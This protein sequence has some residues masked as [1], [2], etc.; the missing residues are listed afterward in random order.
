MFLKMRAKNKM[1]LI[2]FAMLCFFSTFCM[3]EVPTEGYSNEEAQRLFSNAPDENTLST[4]T[5]SN[6][7]VL[8]RPYR[9]EPNKPYVLVVMLP[10]TGGNA[11]QLYN[12]AF[13]FSFHAQKTQFVLALQ[14][15]TASAADYNTGAAWADTIARYEVSVKTT[16][17]A[18]ANEAQLKPLQ[19]ILA[20]YSV[21]G[22]LSW[23]LLQRKTDWFDGAIVMGS[24]ST[25]RGGKKAMQQLKAK[26]AAVYFVIG[27]QDQRKTAMQAASQY[28]A[29]FNI[30]NLLETL[31]GVDH[32]SLSEHPEFS[33]TLSK[34]VDYIQS[35]S[36]QIENK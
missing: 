18:V 30:P 36:K 28:L 24:R 2:T 33:A 20:G 17:D 11:S 13:N 8:L 4:Q 26:Q 22:D 16:M 31:N 19:T 10:F 34:A 1:H 14:P 25:Y 21:G 5:L 7:A 27:S 3:A 35:K 12:A 32:Y 15:E 6:G 9:F 23:A 29:K